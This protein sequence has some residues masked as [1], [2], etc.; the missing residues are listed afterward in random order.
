MLYLRKALKAEKDS[1][2]MRY[3]FNVFERCSEIRGLEC[4]QII[5]FLS[6]LHAKASQSIFFPHFLR[7]TW[8]ISALLVWNAVSTHI[9]LNCL[10]FNLNGLLYNTRTTK[11]IYHRKHVVKEWTAGLQLLCGAWRSHFLMDPWQCVKY[12]WVQGRSAVSRASYSHSYSCSSVR[13]QS[14][15]E[16]GRQIALLL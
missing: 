2:C 13:S 10:N 3:S 15:G 5:Q 9:P 12:K 14:V 4:T 1:V 7:R 16:K 11:S 8:N 6:R